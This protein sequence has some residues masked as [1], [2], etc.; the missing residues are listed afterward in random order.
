MAPV[1]KIDEIAMTEKLQAAAFSN[2]AIL[3]SGAVDYGMYHAF[4]QQLVNAPQQGIVVV[5]LST[6]GGDPKWRA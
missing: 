6:L 5:E 4:R 1:Q 3:L 2:P